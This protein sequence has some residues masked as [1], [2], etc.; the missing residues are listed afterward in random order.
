MYL[1]V[2]SIFCHA[3]QKTDKTSPEIQPEKLV[4]VSF[5]Q[6]HAQTFNRLLL[7]EFAFPAQARNASAFFAPLRETYTISYQSL[8]F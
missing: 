3:R 4:Q 1:A 2:L 6:R 5:P 7:G 8:D